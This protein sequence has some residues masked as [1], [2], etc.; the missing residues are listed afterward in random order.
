MHLETLGSFPILRRDSELHRYFN[1][2]RV[3]GFVLNGAPNCY[4]SEQKHELVRIRAR[5]SVGASWR[6]S[7]LSRVHLGL[8]S[9]RHR[10]R[11]FLKK[12]RRAV[13]ERVKGIDLLLSP[14][15]PLT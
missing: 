4:Q 3:R 2:I 7:V 12:P 13:L 6:M 8:M 15:N 11:D 14:R 9:W 10:G 1:N 5:N